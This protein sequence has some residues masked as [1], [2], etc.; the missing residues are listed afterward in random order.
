MATIIKIKGSWDGMPQ[1]VDNYK[2]FGEDHCL[3]PHGT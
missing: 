3:H 2:H 1:L